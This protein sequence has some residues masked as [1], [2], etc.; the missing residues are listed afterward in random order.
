MSSSLILEKALNDVV[1]FSMIRIRSIFVS[2]VVV[3]KHL[4]SFVC[5][6]IYVCV[7]VCGFMYICVSVCVF[8]Q[9]GWS[10]LHCIYITSRLFEQNQN[11]IGLI[12]VKLHKLDGTRSVLI[13]YLEIFSRRMIILAI[14]TIY[15]RLS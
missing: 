15:F 1:K 7:C 9:K 2:L 6:Y 13:I 3:M 12:G 8:I 10:S 5:Q 11:S 4:K 14:I